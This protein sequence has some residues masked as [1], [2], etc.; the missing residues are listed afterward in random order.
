MEAKIDSEV[1]KQEMVQQIKKMLVLQQKCQSDV[2]DYL[3]KE[4]MDKYSARDL[5]GEVAESLDNKG[6][7]SAITSMLIGA[8]IAI[9]GIVITMSLFS[10]G[11]IV[12]LSFAIIGAGGGLFVKGFNELNT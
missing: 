4:G 2:V 1:R 6:S 9:V 12:G 8:I 5:V 11:W 7:G 10:A 3:V